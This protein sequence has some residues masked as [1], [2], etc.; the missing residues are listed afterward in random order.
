MPADNF[1]QGSFNYLVGIFEKSWGVVGWK[2]GRIRNAR[3]DC[4]LKDVRNAIAPAK[5]FGEGLVCLLLP[6][7]VEPSDTKKLGALRKEFARAT[8]A[9]K[10]ARD[11]FEKQS[12]LCREAD[13]ALSEAAPK[14]RALVKE[15][16]KRRKA[17]R[18]RLR[19][20]HIQK[21]RKME[22]IQK[23]LT[24]NEAAFA[25]SEALDFLR[26]RRYEL[27]PR[28]LAAALAGLPYIRWETSMGRCEKFRDSAPRE[29]PTYSAFCAISYLIRDKRP[30][31]AKKAIEFFREAIPKL[32]AAHENGK[33]SLAGYWFQFKKAIESEWQRCPHPRRL[34]Y[35]LTAALV[36]NLKQP[37]SAIDNVL[38]ARD[39]L[40][41]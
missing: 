41:V 16:R 21:Q 17:R 31:T 38:A 6:E 23:E 9:E 22:T 37:M 27:N 12:D 40:E 24:A 3:K 7:I 34:P 13:Q 36:R 26:R 5:E 1:L 35:E 2:L 10:A 15:E 20:S 14:H 39:R 25:Q 18:S 19:R 4:S 28:N 33:V 11:A 29:H 32:P 30:R 8:K